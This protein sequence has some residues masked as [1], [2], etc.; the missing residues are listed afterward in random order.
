MLL[1][2]VHIDDNPADML[3]KS[4][5]TPKFEHY[6]NLIGY[7]LVHVVYLLIKGDAPLER[8]VHL[9]KKMKVVDMFFVNIIACCFVMKIG[10]IFIMVKIC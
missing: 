2:K 10:F 3:T 5:P 6:S 7:F 1:D 9:V 8:W 4:L